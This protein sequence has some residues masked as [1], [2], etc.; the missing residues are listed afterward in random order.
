M[1]SVRETNDDL[2][3][4]AHFYRT[5]FQVHTPRDA[6]WAGARAVTESERADYA[7]EFVDACRAKGLHA[8]AITDHHDFVLA[9]Y[10]RKAAAQERNAAGDLLAEADRLVVFPGLELTLAVPCQALLILDADFPD[11]RL[12]A[13]LEALAIQATAK[14]EAKLPPV[15]RIDHIQ[16]FEELYNTLDARAWLKGRYIVLPNVTDG[17]YQTLMRSGMHGK[18]KSMPCVGGYLDG[19]VAVKAKPG[20]GNRKIFDGENASWGNKRLALFQTSDSRS[21]DFAE[22]GQHSSWVK[23]ARP[24]AEAIRQACLA[25]ES[26]ISQATPALPEVFIAS[27]HVSNSKFLGPVDL[28]FNRQYNAIIGGRGTGKS[29]ILDY[30]RWCLGDVPV[31]VPLDGEPAVATRRRRL[32]ESTLG[33][34]EADVEVVVVINGIRHVVRRSS[35]SGEIYLKVGDG[36]LTR[37]SESVIQSLL[38]I[39]AYSQKQLSSVSV[40]LD[41]LTR[42]VTAPIH[43]DLESKD[44]EIRD[45]SDRLRENYAS[46]Q[47]ARSTKAAVERAVLA[48]QSL[49]DQADHLR[50]SLTGLSTDD[51]A[52]LD[53]RPGVERSREAVTAWDRHTRRLGESAGGLVDEVDRAIAQIGEV[54]DDTPQDLLEEV[55]SARASTVSATSAFAAALRAAVADLEAALDVDGPVAVATAAA[56]GTLDRLDGAYEEVKGRSSAHTQQLEQLADIEARRKHAAA[57]LATLRGDLERVGDP[58]AAHLALR[59]RLVELHDQRSGMLR[60]QC[61]AVT[62]LSGGLLKAEI[63]RGRGLGPVEERFRAMASG[64]GVRSAKFDALFDGL[65][66]ETEPLV[67]WEAL[68][69]ELE[70]LIL[71]EDGEEF[72]TEQTPILSRLGL[73]LGDQQKIRV[74]MTVD[75]WLDL[76]LTPVEDFP[77]FQYQTK[78]KEYIPFDAASAGQQATALLKV[79][80]SQSGMPLIIDQ[81]EEDLDSQVIED[82]VR[83]LWD[84]KGRRQ[85]I[86][87]SHNANLVVNGDAEL[88][89]ACDYRRSGDQSG[90]KIK[91]TGAIDMPA[92]RDEITHVMEGGEKAFKLRRDKY[93]F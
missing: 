87:A 71:L 29:T 33:S 45:V 31:A 76:A 21:R 58:L 35:S 83:W 15:T 28:A 19:T 37:V 86:V 63:L 75:S 20:S 43:Q 40:R 89:V 84:S 14:D 22:L 62:V 77:D 55:T 16:T 27:V 82:V 57:Q 12:D 17:G 36:E 51:Q 7:R 26:R 46:L 2:D 70:Q 81:P 48:E 3:T 65:K 10:I 47:R 6:N 41:E 61:A 49:V 67:T 39:H 54:P 9:P 69:S 13:V 34:L 72:T 25:Q 60:D 42:F 30:V 8:V 1:S 80:L 66:G 59:A 90:G 85:V 91:L 38:P 11:E 56:F 32:I 50:Q 44:A 79:L 24:T 93:G 64:S 52:V 74:K 73:T 68:L 78:E 92:V 4:G 5:D 18:Y 23:W 53:R 88:V